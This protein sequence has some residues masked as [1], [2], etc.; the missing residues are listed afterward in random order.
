MLIP[1]ETAVVDA[2]DG[3]AAPMLAQVEAWSA[4][5]SGSHNRAGLALQAEAL[6]EAFAPLGGEQALIEG[7]TSEAIA[8]DGATRTLAHGRHLRQTVRPDARVQVLLTGHMDTVFA[9]DHAFQTPRWEA[10]GRLNGPGVA[11]MKGGLA[12]MLAA[13]KAVE[14]SPA[15]DALGYTVLVN[16][17]EEIGSPSSRR[18][19]AEAAT[20]A[21]W[22]L[23]YEPSYLPDGTLAGARWGSGNFAAVIAGRAAHAGRNPEDGRNAILAAADLALRLAA[24][25]GPE[26]RVN[27][28]KIDGGGPTNVV[29]ALAVLRF[30]VRPRSVAAQADAQTAV[31]RAIAEV[32]AAHEV[33][34]TLSGDFARPPKPLDET[35]QRLF[36]V[37]EDCARDL[38]QPFATRESGGVCDGNNLAA[39]G[40]PVVDTLGARGGAIHSAAEYLLTESLVERAK[41]SSLILMRLARRA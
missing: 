8:A 20:R 28:S 36:A 14:R 27:P 13:L 2:L 26:C 22:G 37:V 41:L 35:Q 7:D 17:D 38:R 18:L 15:A 31:A 39:H 5:N 24:L 4:I 1:A 16:A 21:R 12:I 40:L 3:E 32:A 10:A 25:V 30:N 9:T 33:A 23:T 11:D 6:A 19:L 34:I 29:P